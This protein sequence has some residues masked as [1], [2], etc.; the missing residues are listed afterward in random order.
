MEPV[1]G[2]RTFAASG[3]V[4]DRFMGRYSRPLA[5]EF[6]TFAGVS[7]GSQVLDVG[8]GPGALTTELAGRLGADRVA[9]CDPSAPF[10][11][12]C[13]A[14]N[15]GVDVRPGAAEELPFDDSSFDL[16][17]FQLVLHFVSDPPRAAAEAERVVRPGGVVATCVWDFG[18][19]MQMLRA[20]WDAAM[21]LDP[22]APAEH[23]VLR[24]GRPGEISQWLSD[25]GLEQVSES[26]MTVGSTYA[27]FDELWWGFLAG[28]GPAGSYCVAL[29]PER[30]ELL[31]RALHKRLG[32]PT[33]AFSLEAVARVGR[34][35][36]R[37]V[38]TS[39]STGG[40]KAG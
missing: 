23:R 25:A 10:V 2:A 40:P 9:A 18:E 15:P 22:D 38:A 31:Y 1:A 33:G 16:V 20:F 34:A 27:D 26:T 36:R 35:V 32:S 12:A 4:Y 29:P 30:R 8:C 17:L 21:S 37:P 14:R 7:P 19:E 39:P 6:A 24:F 5:A 28:I 13:T 3:E 11:A